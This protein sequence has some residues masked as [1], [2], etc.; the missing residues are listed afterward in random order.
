[1]IDSTQACPCL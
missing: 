1:M